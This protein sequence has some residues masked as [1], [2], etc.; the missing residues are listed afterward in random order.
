MEEVPRFSFIAIELSRNMNLISSKYILCKFFEFKNLIKDAAINHEAFFERIVS[1]S[2]DSLMIQFQ[3]DTLPNP[4]F[5]KIPLGI[6][7]GKSTVVIGNGKA[8][9]TL[10]DRSTTSPNAWQSS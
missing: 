3:K 5:L 10:K 1:N 6:A 4:G 2:S 9:S 7:I 8:S